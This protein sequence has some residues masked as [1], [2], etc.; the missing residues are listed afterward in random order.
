MAEDGGRKLGTSVTTPPLHPPFPSASLQGSSTSEGVRLG[1]FAFLLACRKLGTV[2]SHQPDRNVVI[3]NAVKDLIGRPTK[4][5]ILR[6]RSVLRKKAQNDMTKAAKP[7]PTPFIPHSL[8]L[9]FRDLRPR[10]G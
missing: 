6:T 8:P 5:K 7:P 9:R 3:L 4:R 1:F 2:S 10:K